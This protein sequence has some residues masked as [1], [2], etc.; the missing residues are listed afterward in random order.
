LHSCTPNGA[1]LWEEEE[2]EPQEGA[3]AA[4]A[5]SAH[6]QC[7]RRH[8]HIFKFEF[9]IPTELA[10]LPVGRMEQDTLKSR[11]R[12]SGNTLGPAPIPS[13]LPPARKENYT[14]VW[15]FLGISEG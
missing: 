6:A 2:E 8:F 15:L 11:H 1:C 3:G 10:T 9:S 14:H 4:S 7:R 12:L 13:A 5:A